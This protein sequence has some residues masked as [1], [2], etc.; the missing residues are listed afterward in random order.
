MKRIAIINFTGFRG[1]WGCQ[2]TSV[3]LVKFIA[4]CFASD[5]A[6][7][8]SFVPL[9]PSSR[10]DVRY[11]QELDKVYGAFTK[12]S[13]QTAEAGSSLR[14]LE[15]AC[16]ERYGFWADIV[17]RSDLVVFQAE[18]TM[19]LGANF[20]RGPRLMLL[21]FVAKHAWNRMVISLNQSF[22]SHEEVVRKNA[23]E[24]FGSFDFSGFREGASVELARQN[25]VTDAAYVPDLAF[26][27]PK[28]DLP[29]AP[30]AQGEGYFAVSG[31]ALK[32]PDRYALIM[33]QAE[34]IREATGLKPLLALSRDYRMTLRALLKWKRGTY[35]QVP[36]NARYA[37]VTGLF[38]QCKFLLSGR[39]HM[40]ILA[41]A[42]GTPNIILT[43]NS[44]K[45]EGL[46]SLLGSSRPVHRF[47]EIDAIVTEA[48]EV[49][50]NEQSERAAIAA[51]VRLI[52]E[53]I[54]RAQHHIA[55]IINGERLDKFED[56]L[57]PYR[58]T[59]EI[60]ARYHAFGRGK[61][62][63]P[64]RALP[65]KRLGKNR[66]MLAILA[67]L[68]DGIL[69]DR[70]RSTATLRKMAAADGAVKHELARLSATTPGLTDFS[71]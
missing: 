45:N 42:A 26:L 35:A 56:G 62:E 66:S 36:F 59:P 31:S 6:L 53:T 71:G 18:G 1:N 14:Y 4:G 65:G 37:Q 24:A 32:D 54:L 47:A 51:Q 10:V 7:D 49:S 57:P 64:S 68:L 16:V 55:G 38:A 61:G 63:K 43:G 21:P 12:V 5:E 8:F 28:A 20:A 13:Q 19:G 58:L 67:P 25:G 30:L 40:S 44:F 23:S 41:A 69:E 46:A 39:Y 22:Y 48:V 27:S 29:K 34:M 70:D 50:A 2:A 33:K 3:E 17:K 11:D 15:Q 9:L 60:L 52:R